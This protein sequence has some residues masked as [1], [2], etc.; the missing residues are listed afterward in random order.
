MQRS[1]RTKI[2]LL[3]VNKGKKHKQ[4]WNERRV[5]KW[6]QNFHI[7]LKYPFRILVHNFIFIFCRCNS[8]IKR[9]FHC[10]LFSL[11]AFFM[12]HIKKWN[13]LLLNRDVK[14]RAERPQEHACATKQKEVVVSRGCYKRP[15]IKK[16]IASL[17]RQ[18]GNKF[19]ISNSSCTTANFSVVLLQ[20]DIRYQR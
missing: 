17:W 15:V 19:C 1:G 11:K 5:S 20:R 3:W 4:V 7:W 2:L 18:Q 10:L 8:N 13:V 16:L 9:L 6:W 14:K 12:I